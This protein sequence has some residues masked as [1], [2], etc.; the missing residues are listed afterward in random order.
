MVIIDQFI[1][2][3]LLVVL[4]IRNEDLQTK[5]ENLRNDIDQLHRDK[6]SPPEKEP[7]LEGVKKIRNVIDE[8]NK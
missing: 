6:T 7:D 2:M 4:I 5:V 3:L 1:I 8:V